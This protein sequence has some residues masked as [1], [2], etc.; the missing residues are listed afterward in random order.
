MAA[1]LREVT[2]SVVFD[3]Y[4]VKVCQRPWNTGGRFSTKARAASL[5]SSLAR[6]RSIPYASLSSPAA[7]SPYTADVQVP[8][9]VAQRH[10]RPVRQLRRQRHCLRRQLLI[11]DH[12][13]GQP[14]R[15]DPSRIQHVGQEIQLARLCRADKLRQKPRPA[16]ITRKAD[17]RERRRHPRAAS[18]DTQIACQRQR[19]P[20]SGGDAIQHRNR[21]LRHL[22]QQ[23]R[24]L[25]RDTQQ[26]GP[27]LRRLRTALRRNLRLHPHVATGTERAAGTGQHNATDRFIH[28]TL[29]EPRAQ[30]LHHVLGQRVQPLRPV[31]RDDRDAVLQPIQQ[32][33]AHH[34]D[35]HL[36]PAPRYREVPCHAIR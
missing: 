9:H 3:T 17:L 27:T 10:A 26:I 8:L 33:V 21:R 13:V 36:P 35:I 29:R 14:Q 16:V 32:F 15:L 23:P 5:W 20:R 7:R 6:E 22:V 25:H 1:R 34:A 19:Q 2:Q 31:K 28:S 11:G 24:R 18:G 4:E 30:R 12:A